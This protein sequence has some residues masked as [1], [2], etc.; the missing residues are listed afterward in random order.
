M[1]KQYRELF[2]GVHA[3]RR[4][5]TEVMNMKREES[6]RTHR[7]PRAALIAAVLLIVLA[8][9]AVAAEYFGWIRIKPISGWLGPDGPVDGSGY[10][11]TY[12]NNGRFPAE[13]LPEE[14]FAIGEEIGDVHLPERTIT[15]DSWTDCEEFLGV[16]LADNPQLEQMGKDTAQIEDPDGSASNGHAYVRLSYAKR[17]PSYITVSAHYGEEDISVRQ[18]AILRTQYAFESSAPEDWDI[19]VPQNGEEPLMQETY[20]T[21]DGT[22]AVILTD[23]YDIADVAGFTTCYASFIRSNARFTLTVSVRT[24]IYRE[25]TNAPDAL[26]VM[27]EI[28]D[29]YE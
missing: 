21:A 29:A 14:V 2:D 18:D 17:M 10:A 7:I 19:L 9:T 28:L 16:E 23:T 25:P 27:K 22:E 1:E 5:K 26:E 13:N 8:G 12:E 24:H 11:L 3:S 6:K 15:F 4:L 20:V